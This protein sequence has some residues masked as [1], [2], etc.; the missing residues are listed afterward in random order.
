LSPCLAR[1]SLARLIS[2]ALVLLAV[3]V[4]SPGAFATPSVSPAVTGRDVSWPQCEG[5]PLPKGQHELVVV[6][7]T[8]GTA[9][10]RNPCLREQLGWA[11]SHARQVATYTMVNPPTKAE[12]RADA[13]G[14]AGDCAGR[15]ARSALLC[16]LRNAGYAEAASTLAIL[17]AAGLHPRIV[18][19]DV[20]PRSVQPWS[21]DRTANA[22][23]LSG[24]QAGLVAGG[25]TPGWYSTWWLWRQV[26]GTW[27]P[28]A[29]APEWYAIGSGNGKALRAAC[30]MSFAG[31][32]TLLTQAVW[33][34]HDV[35][36][37]CPAGRQELAAMHVGR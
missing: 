15:A 7:L 33:G 10:H 35:D 1:V 8:N 11:R 29:G 3:C 26:A 20:E 25:V 19:V 36:F 5:M 31:G 13:T 6:G 34:Q 30:A 28:L 14:P 23:V 27:R 32:P 24:L 16:A 12:L 2:A 21:R 4:G 17:R 37:V 18:W 22:A 9:L